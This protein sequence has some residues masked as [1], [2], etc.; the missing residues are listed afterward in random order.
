MPGSLGAC[1]L[2]RFQVEPFGSDKSRHF[3]AEPLVVNHN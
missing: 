1:D 3:L 2:G